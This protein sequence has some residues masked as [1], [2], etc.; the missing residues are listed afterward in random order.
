MQ[1][2]RFPQ[3]TTQKGGCLSGINVFKKKVPAIFAGTFFHDKEKNY[4]NMPIILLYVF[5][6]VGPKIVRA[7]ITTTATKTRIN[8]Y[9]TR[10]WPFIP[11]L[12]IGSPPFYSFSHLIIEHLA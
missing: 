2:R 10:P 7:A 4:G 5:P 8:A 1:G 11:T 9:S 12:C 3:S 6:I